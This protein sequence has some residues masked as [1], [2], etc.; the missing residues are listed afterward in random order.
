L[1]LLEKII[2]IRGVASEK[3]F[4]TVEKL[5]ENPVLVERACGGWLASGLVSGT[6]RIGVTGDSEGDALAQFRAAA[7]DW[8]RNLSL[9]RSDMVEGDD[10]DHLE[11]SAR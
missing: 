4:S 2:I 7:S 5:S 3:G 8:E 9:S 10:E 6:L 1:I 11:Q